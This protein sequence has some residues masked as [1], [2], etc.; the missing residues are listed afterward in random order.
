MYVGDCACLGTLH[1]CFAHSRSGTDEHDLHCSDSGDV[2]Y[3][4]YIAM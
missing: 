2:I 1:V 4:V 3:V